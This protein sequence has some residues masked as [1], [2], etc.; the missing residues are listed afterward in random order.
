MIQRAETQRWALLACAL[1]WGAQAA[2]PVDTQLEQMRDRIAPLL[3]EVPRD[4]VH[5]AP[6]PGFYELR[7]GENYGYLT[8]DG[9]F[10]IIGDALDLQTGRAL[11]E[12]R[13]RAQRVAELDAAPSPILF[14]ANGGAVPARTVTVFTDPDCRYCRQLHAQ[15][16]DYRAAGLSIRYLLM[17]PGG[18]GSPSYQRASALLCAEAPQ[19]A[20][21]AALKGRRAGDAGGRTDCSALLD[22][23]LALAT[24]MQ[25]NATPALVLPDG[26]VDYGA[27]SAAELLERVAT[28][29]ASVL[30]PVRSATR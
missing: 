10:L 6:I 30:P 8:P 17:P 29:A 21:D 3:P 5:R 18:P 14:A 1:L 19:L 9:R 16:D 7:S 20:L 27:P 12:E 23:H 24:Q 15:M 13:R 28:P 2:E 22:R 4:N 26:R 11:T 25:L